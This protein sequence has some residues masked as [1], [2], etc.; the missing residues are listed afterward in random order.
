VKAGVAE[1]TMEMMGQ[2]VQIKMLFEDWGAKVR[3]ETI[4]DMGGKKVH[5]VIITKDSMS[6]MLDMVTKTGQKMKGMSDDMNFA[7]MRQKN[8]KQKALPRSVKRPSAA[9]NVSSMKLIRMRM[10]KSR[11]Q[12]QGHRRSRI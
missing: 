2:K 4:G 8:S 5:Q 11:R 1:G 6:Y 10:L 12:L 3:N 9:E 7:N